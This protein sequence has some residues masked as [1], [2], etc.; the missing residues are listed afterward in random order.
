MLLSKIL[1]KIINKIRLI[2]LK[3]ISTNKWCGNPH[4]IQPIQACGAG[5]IYFGKNVVIGVEK[6][7]H[8]FST[9]AYIEARNK[10]SKI[11]IGDDTWINNGVVLIAEHS[12]INI[13]K[14]VLIGTKVEIIDSNFHGKN[15]A[16]RMISSHLDAKPVIVG[17][18]VFIGSNVKIMKGV[19]IGAGSIIGNSS[20]VVNDVPPNSIAAGNP[21]RKIADID[22]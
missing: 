14:R 6:S 8:L 5:K 11:Y 20:V 17:D 9:Y 22:S 19:K 10:N 3:G 7:P 15:I 13:G 12:E 18:D 21:A 1:I 2:V 16:N 4:I